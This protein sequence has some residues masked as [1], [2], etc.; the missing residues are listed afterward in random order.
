[1]FIVVLA[2][3][4]AKPAL[5][6]STSGAA[7][8]RGNWVGT[9]APEKGADAKDPSAAMAKA[10]MGMMQLKLKIAEGNAFTLTMMGVPI[11]GHFTA[12]GSHLTFKMEKMLGKTPEELKKASAG[13][14]N[15]SSFNDMEKPME[16]DVSPDHQTITLRSADGA[17]GT[18]E[19]KRTAEVPEGSRAETV[20]PEEKEFVAHWTG[21][22]E[23]APGSIKG[24][25]KGQEDIAKAMLQSME[26]DLRK[27]NTFSMNMVFELTGTWSVSGNTLTLTPKGIAGMDQGTPSGTNQPIVLTIS[28]DKTSLTSASSDK[29]KLTFV[30]SAG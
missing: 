15:P 21:K 20:K 25:D 22:A 2:L 27:D 30:K 9:V 14:S 24:A 26:L 6:A 12:S 5:N 16:G 19:F 1:M 29:G 18:M 4:C 11:Q 23:V 17:K 8:L 10:M 3:G 28:A 13:S 7:D